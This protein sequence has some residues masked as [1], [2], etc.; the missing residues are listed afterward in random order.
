MPMRYRTKE[1]YENCQNTGLYY[2]LGTSRQAET[3][4]EEY[5]D[6]VY[7]RNMRKHRRWNMEVCEIL[8]SFYDEAEV[9]RQT[10]AQY[11]WLLQRL[12]DI[13]PGEILDRTA[14]LRVLA[15]GMASREVKALLTEWC[16]ENEREMK[17][18]QE[19]YWKVERDH[20][21]AGLLDETLLHNLSWLH[22]GEILEW[23]QDGENLV[24]IL[25]YGERYVLTFEKAEVLEQEG[26]PA[27]GQWLYREVYPLEDG[28]VEVHILIWKGNK[29]LDGKLSY[30]TVKAENIEYERKANMKY[31]AILFDLDGTLTESGIGITKSVQQALERMGKPE[32]DLEK[33]R[34]FVGPPLKDQFMAYAGFTEE[35]AEQ[36]IKLYR[37]RYTTVGLFENAVYDGVEDMLKALKE[38]GYLLAVAS[39]KPEV[40]VK[41][42]LEYFHLN[43]YFTEMV[44]S[45]LNG[46][47]SRKSEVVEE[48]LL[49]LGLKE[50]RDHV[51]MVG[52]KEHDVF[53][54][55]EAGMECV[56]VAWGYGTEEELKAAH[57]MLTISHPKELAEYLI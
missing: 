28:S 43:H 16:Q 12:K 21:Q 22:D 57:P 46:G 44:G 7:A 3:F 47:R 23:K 25:E 51:L 39:S 26:N 15:L 11:Q 33:L 29:T 18:V 30:L 9:D 5:F 34:V 19:E 4:S 38:A 2:N 55:R 1:W 50:E 27:G 52:D 14:D 35:E 56:A 10:E 42:I 54:A 48:A 32:P 40:F 53:G 24:M 13:L 45:E 31:K 6:K 37:E 41:Q 36:A 49:R 17:A 8:G 20:I